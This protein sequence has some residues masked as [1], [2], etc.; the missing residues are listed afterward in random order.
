MTNRPSVPASSSAIYVV[1]LLSVFL[2][3]IPSQPRLITADKLGATVS[4]NLSVEILGLTWLT[5]KR[6][7]LEQVMLI[8]LDVFVC[9]GPLAGRV[10]GF[11]GPE[12]SVS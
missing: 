2:F 12:A 11:R 1:E 8:M 9:L 10:L 4:L 7:L 3:I 5:L 6:W